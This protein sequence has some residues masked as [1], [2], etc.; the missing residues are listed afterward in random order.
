MLGLSAYLMGCTRS[1]ATR[2]SSDCSGA[3]TVFFKLSA[4]L[5]RKL[6]MSKTRWKGKRVRRNL[7]LPRRPHTLM[8]GLV[9]YVRLQCTYNLGLT[10]RL[11]TPRRPLDLGYTL[12]ENQGHERHISM[13]Q[14]ARIHTQSS[15]LFAYR[16]NR[17]AIFSCFF[18]LLSLWASATLKNV[19][20]TSVSHFGSIAV[21]S[22]C[23]DC[24]LVGTS[25]E[26]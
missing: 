10:K 3:Q 25:Q 19:G 20:A 2:T 24:E 15:W 12:H 5:D 7:G 4:A 26:A 1:F 18:R 16:S 8:I 17:G 11:G 9:Y 14:T 22:R 13:T 23:R 6:A 21:T